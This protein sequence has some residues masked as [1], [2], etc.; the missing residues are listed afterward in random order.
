MEL[1]ESQKNK[2]HT[3][4]EGYRYRRARVL[5]DGGASWRCP[6]RNCSGRVKISR[7]DVV[8]VVS[9]HNHAPDPNKNKAF[10][11]ISEIRKRAIT[12]A[13]TPRHI[14]QQATAGVSLEVACNL[15]EYTTA[16]RMIHRQRRKCTDSYAPVNSLSDIQIPNS[17]KQTLRHEDFLLWD[18]G[19]DDSKRILMF[20]TS[21]N[22]DILQEHVHWFIDG[23]FKVAP[24]IFLQVFTIHA[25]ID[26]SAVPLVYVLVPDKCEESYIKIFR[27]LKELKPTLNPASIMSDFEKASQNACSIIFPEARLFGCLFHLGQNLWRKIQKLNLTTAYCDDDNFRTCAKMVL[28]LSFVPVSDVPAAFEDLVDNCP[29]LMMPLIEYWE[30]NYIGRQRRGRRA[31]PRFGIDMWNVRDRVINKLPRTNNSVEAWHR[32]FQQTINNVHPSV[33]KLL[34]QFRQEQDHVEI[35]IERSRLGFKRPTA[36]KSKYIKL[37]ERLQELMPLYGSI[38]NL[39]Y[40]R[41]LAQNIEI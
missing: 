41:R 36:S 4:H 19:A 3:M 40:L 11:I 20:G 26:A 38:T 7:E 23:T 35:K 12:A 9:E 21:S 32:S 14:I 39:E 5:V 37:N 29:P 34:E 25:L 31:A 1:A 10:K 8:T 28:S 22:F 33:Y 27:K 2:T 18:T 15:P 16:Q 6:R 24:N 17:L 13:E 30:D